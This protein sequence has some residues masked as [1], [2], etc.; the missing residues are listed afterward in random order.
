MQRYAIDDD[1]PSSGVPNEE[2]K[3]QPMRGSSTNIQTSNMESTEAIMLDKEAENSTTVHEDSSTGANVKA[4]TFQL[5]NRWSS[6]WTSGTGPRIG[7]V[8]EY[9]PKLQFQALEHVNLSPR[10]AP[11]QFPSSAP[12]PSPRPSP[13][14]HL[15]PALAYMGLPS[16]RLLPS[17]T[18]KVS[19]G[20]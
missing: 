1:D 6:K 7:C 19:T 16:P 17:L 20:N 9:P 12:I 18:P 15:S 3:S 13:K 5:A 10:T 14:V 11:G 4:P 2:L 8:R